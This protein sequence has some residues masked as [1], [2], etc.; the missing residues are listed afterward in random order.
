MANLT[1]QVDV[2][3]AQ[4]SI[5][6][7][8]LNTTS[9]RVFLHQNP[10]HL[11]RLLDDMGL[12]RTEADLLA[13]LHPFQALWKIGAHTAL[14]DHIIAADEWTFADTDHAMRANGAG[15]AITPTPTGGPTDSVR[16]YDGR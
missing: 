16:S 4:A 5:A 12:T 13:R 2:G 14:V 1:S 11:H 7:G 6:A 3:K 9:V 15:F 10:E 8:L